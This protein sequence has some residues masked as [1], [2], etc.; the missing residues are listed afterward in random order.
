MNAG[1]QGGA[2]EAPETITRGRAPAET[3]AV[4]AA[5]DG[6][7]LRERGCGP[8]GCG[9]PPRQ[10]RSRMIIAG[11]PSLPGRL[12]SESPDAE[13][14]PDR[15]G[16]LRFGSSRTDPGPLGRRVKFSLLD[17]MFII[18]Q[19]ATPRPTREQRSAVSAIR[20]RRHGRAVAQAPPPTRFACGRPAHPD[21]PGDGLDCR[22]GPRGR[23]VGGQ[24]DT[25]SL[26][27]DRPDGQGAAGTPRRRFAPVP[28]PR[29]RGSLDAAFAD[30]G[31]ESAICGQHDCH[32]Y[33]CPNRADGDHRGR[34]HIA[35]HVG[36]PVGQTAQESPD[37]EYRPY[38]RGARSEA[39]PAG[40]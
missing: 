37:A 32:V 25:V 29:H 14:R 20:G 1:P 39:E 4:T 36:G 6:S 16:A 7:A 30:S 31:H 28:G 38:R 40:T 18:K 12:A 15:R 22:C 10:G 5:G 34:C 26:S 21:A 19:P 35:D 27:T 33:G 8:K 17:I 23:Y 3:T 9:A 11:I 24:D 2:A 13:Y